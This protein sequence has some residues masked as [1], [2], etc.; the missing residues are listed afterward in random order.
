MFTYTWYVF[1]YLHVTIACGTVKIVLIN[2]EMVLIGMLRAYRYSP[3]LD[4][5]I[6]I[7]LLRWSISGYVRT[8]V[9]TVHTYYYTY[10]T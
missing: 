3:E 6:L 8:Y 10:C 1:V 4:W 7:L 9:C 5:K 2:C